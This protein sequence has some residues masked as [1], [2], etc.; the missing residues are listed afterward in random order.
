MAT[1]PAYTVASDSETTGEEKTSSPLLEIAVGIDI[2]TSQC[3]IAVWNGSQVEIMKDTKNQKLMRSYVTF[4]NDIPSGGVSNQL[5]HEYEMLTGAT[6][7]NMK[8]L[9]GR[10]DTDPVVM[11]ART[12]H[13]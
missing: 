8:H 11:Q 7:F 1:E 4:K 10:L 13:F 2:G 3:S 6:V 12:S 9:I 5:A